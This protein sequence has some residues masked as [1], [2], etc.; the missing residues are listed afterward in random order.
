MNS[1]VISGTPRTNSMN[2]DREQPA[3][4]ACASA[5]RAP[6]G[7]RAAATPR[8]RPTRPRWSPARRPTATVSTI[9]RPISG[10]AVQQDERA[11]S[12]GRRRNRARRGRGAA[13]R[14]TAARRRR[15]PAS[16]RTHRRAS[17]PGSDRSRDEI[18]Q[19]LPHERPAGADLAMLHGSRQA[20]R[21]APVHTASMSRNLTQLRDRPR[22]SSSTMMIVSAMLN[23]VDNR[24]SRSQPTAP[25]HRRRRRLRREVLRRARN[26]ISATASSPSDMVMAAPSPFHQRHAAVVDVHQ[27][28]R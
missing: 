15:P 25:R 24:F 20:S 4:P 9:G 23:G 27:R 19:P 14:A 18:G 2:I 22:A 8:C 28:T 13:R 3:P 1:T 11:R 26:A 21:S 17:A 5:A 6:A 12:A 10:K 16:R 7:C